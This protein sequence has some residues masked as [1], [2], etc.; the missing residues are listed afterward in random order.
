MENKIMSPSREGVKSSAYKPT[1]SGGTKEGTTALLTNTATGSPSQVGGSPGASKEGQITAHDPAANH[2]G[3][4]LPAKGQ[5]APHA[6]G[7]D[8]GMH[9]DSATYLQPKSASQKEFPTTEP[10]KDAGVTQPPRLSQKVPKWNVL[11]D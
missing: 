8:T 10:S 5:R 2:T 3:T 1:G 11:P 6:D 7:S 4:L 9:E